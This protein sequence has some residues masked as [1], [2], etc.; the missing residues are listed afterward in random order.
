[1]TRS[2]I[3][4]TGNRPRCGKTS[5]ANILRSS[6]DFVR[7]GVAD[8]MR[9]MMATF[10][11]SDE[12]ISGSLKDIPNAKLAGITP[13]RMLQVLGREVPDALGRP[14]L[15]GELW[16]EAASPWEEDD[17]SIVVDDHR[18]PY[19]QKYFGRY[20]RDVYVVRVNRDGGEAVQ[21]ATHAAETQVLVPHY[22]INNN[23]SLEDL[24]NVSSVVMEN[25]RQVRSLMSR[26]RGAPRVGTMAD[27]K[28]AQRKRYT[29]FA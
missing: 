9:K 18:Y 27:S 13:R 3:A 22:T 15:W 23:G 2:V 20:A 4:L 5:V 8:P 21:G 6:Y 26:D 16:C 10:G 28:I 17:S 1:M 12:E 19:E 29:R 7:I 25:I 14:E 24:F 11:L